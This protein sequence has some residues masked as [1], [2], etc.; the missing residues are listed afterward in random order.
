MQ[1]EDMLNKV[2]LQH[3]ADSDWL[4][5]KFPDIWKEICKEENPKDKMVEMNMEDELRDIR[6]GKER[7]PTEILHDMGAIEAKYKLKIGKEKKDAF[8]LRI[9]R[10]EY[11]ASM[12]TKGNKA[13]KIETRK[14]TARELVEE[15]YRE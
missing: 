2:T 7:N 13:R 11:T 10:K 9:G 1:T 15:M 4:T 6:L 12:A 3:S 5:G 14:A 8:V